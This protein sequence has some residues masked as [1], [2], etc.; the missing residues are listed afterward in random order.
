[1]RRIGSVAIRIVVAI[2]LGLF[3]DH[4]IKNHENN[5]LTRNVTSL[6]SVYHYLVTFFTPTPELKATTL[7]RIGNTS[8]AQFVNPRNVCLENLYIGRVLTSLAAIN[9]RIVVLDMRFDPNTCPPEDSGEAA[10]IE[11]VKTLC[12][13][14]STKVFVGRS[15]KL[16]QRTSSEDVSAYDLE[17]AVDF[18]RQKGCEC[19]REALLNIDQDSRKVPLGWTTR[20]QLDSLSLA[21]AKAAGTK[22]QRARLDQL[23]PESPNPFVSFLKPE[24]FRRSMVPASDFICASDKTDSILGWR[25]CQL[26]ELP[27]TA[28]GIKKDIVIIGDDWP[29][30]D[31]HSSVVG[32]FPGFALQ[33]NFIESLLD[34]RVFQPIND[35]LNTAVGICLYVVIEVIF[36]IG[37]RPG[38]FGIWIEPIT[39]VL[40]IVILAACCMV[41]CVW[42]GLYPDPEIGMLAFLGGRVVDLGVR[43][44]GLWRRSGPTVS[45]EG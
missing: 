12:E 38:L 34:N 40:A 44:K 3:C 39:I 11:G 5:L 45:L 16:E 4:W 26:Q 24:Q 41:V 1:M 2:S 13:S 18:R 33:A 20:P 6:N 37:W 21:V 25:S 10:V 30:Q 29:E 35:S 36:L 19:V 14:R 17:P 8:V 32:N 27:A 22:D 31:Q 23:T 9:P 43:F 42:S 15:V 28:M 7:I